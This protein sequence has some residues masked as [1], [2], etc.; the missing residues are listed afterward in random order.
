MLEAGCTGGGD[1]YKGELGCTLSFCKWLSVLIVSSTSGFMEDAQGLLYKAFNI[2]ISGCLCEPLGLGA[3]IQAA[4]PGSRSGFVLIPTGSCTW[5]PK[6]LKTM[7][8][9]V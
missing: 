3:R 2:G 6:V 8:Q 4:I 9:E 5:T 7:A 1:L